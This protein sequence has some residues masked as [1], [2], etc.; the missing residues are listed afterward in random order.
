MS[1]TACKILRRYLTPLLKEE[2][3]KQGLSLEQVATDNKL[4]VMEIKQIET[5]NG[6]ASI[7]KSMRLLRYYK[8]CIKVELADSIS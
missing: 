7:K 2:R 8:K 6:T 5:Q 4:T 1:T 3:L